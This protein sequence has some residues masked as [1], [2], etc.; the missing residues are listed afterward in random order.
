[1]INLAKEKSRYNQRT[2]LSTVAFMAKLFMGIE[3]GPQGR[4]RVFAK[5]HNL[6]EKK[7]EVA[8][9]KF[10]HHGECLE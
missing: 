7:Q 4:P 1:M 5:V 6:R 9:L 3:H 8:R 2:I 10:Q